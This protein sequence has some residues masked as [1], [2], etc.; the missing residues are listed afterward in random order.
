MADCIRLTS[1]ESSTMELLCHISLPAVHC[2]GL[3]VLKLVWP[4]TGSPRGNHCTVASTRACR[5][6]RANILGSLRFQKWMQCNA[7]FTRPFSV[8]FGCDQRHWSSCCKNMSF[9]IF[10]FELFCYLLS[11]WENMRAIFCIQ[12]ANE[13]ISNFKAGPNWLGHSLVSE[14]Q[15]WSS[16]QA[17]SKL[18]GGCA[19]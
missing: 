8:K 19:E 12:R 13:N 16:P 14:C 2:H 11:W 5:R 9:I 3:L 18:F 4:M 1:T 15:L 7:D 10:Y 6:I 17:A